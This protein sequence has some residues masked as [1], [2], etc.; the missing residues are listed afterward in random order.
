M[1]YKGILIDADDT[2]FDFQAGN[3]R[4]VYQLCDEIGYTH[5]DRYEQYEEINLACWAALERGEMTQAQLQTLRWQRFFDRYG[6]DADGKWAGERGAAL[7]G[8][9]AIMLPHAEETA[10]AIAEKLP[11]LILTN[12]ITSV[13]KSRLALSPL[14]DFVAGMVISQEVGCAKPGP[15]IF[16]IALR[17]L[18]IARNEALMIGDGISSDVLGANNAGVD[19]CWYNPH[20]KTLPVGV[21]TEYEI[22]DI[23]DSAAIALSD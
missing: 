9:Q 13:Q 1:R 6:I 11:I 19:V 22:D 16:D 5:P 17:K 14:S 12:G 10:R 23:R 21:H 3:R 15:E 20:H 4:A 18:G 8:M 2:L 7:L